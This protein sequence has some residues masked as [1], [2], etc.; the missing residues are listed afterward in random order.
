MFAWVGYEGGIR[1]IYIINYLKNDEFTNSV[2]I[3]RD[4]C[5]VLNVTTCSFVESKLIDNLNQSI[6]NVTSSYRS[7]ARKGRLLFGE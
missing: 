3:I 1:G 6:V 5:R 2:I 4:R 7:F